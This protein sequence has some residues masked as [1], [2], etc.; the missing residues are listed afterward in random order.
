MAEVTISLSNLLKQYSVVNLQDG[1]RI[2][3]HNRLA[4]ERFYKWASSAE[5]AERAV[6][7]VR[8]EAVQADASEFSEGLVAEEV[9]AEPQP[10]PEEI[11][12]Q[13]LDDARELADQML[14]D[15]AQRAKQTIADANNEAQA[16]FEE[17]KALGYEEGA[18]QREQELEELKLQLERE[19]LAQEE[20][21]VRRRQELE[22]DFRDRQER[23]EADIV[24]ALIPVFE[25]VFGIQ[26]GEKR[27][28]LLSLIANL[29]ANVEVG[30]KLR[31]RVNEA[32]H[33]MLTEYMPK[34]RKQIGSD[35][36]LEIMQDNKLSDG[37]CQ[38]ET[39]FGIFDCGIDTHFTNLIRDIRSLI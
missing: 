29:L 36:S 7:T 28:I 14:N 24:D 11:A 4:E 8:D 17:Q 2:I 3:N 33:A 35:I 39:A 19:A 22:A 6:S 18:K 34:L 37:D 5:A 21:M 20:D 12:K 30:D 1:K 9:V 16:L 23:M 32:D 15:A 26:F 31:I 13:I 27:E 10:D 38:I 25:K